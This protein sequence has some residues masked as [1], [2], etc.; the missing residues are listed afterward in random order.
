MVSR[1]S[2]HV[3]KTQYISVY[4]CTLFNYRSSL[5]TASGLLMWLKVNILTFPSLIIVVS[6]SIITS[7][8]LVFHSFLL[9]SGQTTWEM[10][11]RFK[12]PYLKELDPPIN[13]FDEGC[14]LNSIHF[15]CC[16]SQDWETLYHTRLNQQ[17]Q[18]NA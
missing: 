13:P 17:L 8:L 14:I 12:I 16:P 9:I 6:G 15:L 1:Q 7:M 4:L 18:T 5:Q 11:S 2:V 3:C 10:A